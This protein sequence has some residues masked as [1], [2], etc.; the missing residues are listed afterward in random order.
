[1]PDPK[2]LLL[3][4][5]DYELPEERI[6]QVPPERRG[7]S[8]LMVMN[9]T[10]GLGIEHRMFAELGDLLPEGALLVANNSRV[11]PARLRGLRATGGK[12]EF[13]LLTPLPVV[14]EAG[15][16][17]PGRR[18]AAAG[19]LLRAGG[20]LKPGEELS[21]GASIAVKLVRQG[22]FGHWDVELSWEGD[23]AACY[24]RAGSV[25]LPPY[26][27]RLPVEADLD[28]YQT[29]YAR[30]EK[31][32]SVAAPTAGLHFTEDLRA[33][34]LER[35]FG[36]KEVTLYVGYGTFSPVRCENILDH[37]MHAELVEVPEETAEA[38][39]QA[40]REGRPVIAV[41]TTSVRSLEGCR[42]AC[43]RLQAWKG[44]TDIFLYP[45]KAFHVVDG[46]VTNFHLPKSS[47][48]MLV[49]ALAGR[50]RILEAYRQA[51]AAGYRFFSYGDAMFIRP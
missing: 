9:R 10:G 24:A 34:L 12:V 46:L 38:V 19:G 42:A 13:L 49:S 37:A 4:S 25:P 2:D 6:A 1:M 51:V 21:F 5:Y 40:R 16:Q 14:V 27:R 26:I 45:G 20:R 11:L 32:G 33:R 31:T 8:R 7:A 44:F 17:G 18:T 3:E 43:G 15:G 30:P 28:R 22:E 36:W 48:V 29:V 50:E 39:N 23:L 35:G 47:L 41:G